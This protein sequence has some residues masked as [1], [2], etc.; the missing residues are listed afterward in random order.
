MSDDGCGDVDFDWDDFL[1]IP[2][3]DPPTATTGGNKHGQ[4]PWFWFILVT[5]LLCFVIFWSRLHASS[6]GL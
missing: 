5:L 3:C 4:F 1:F 2:C 6:T